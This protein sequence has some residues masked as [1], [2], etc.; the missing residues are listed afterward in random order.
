MCGALQLFQYIFW[1]INSTLHLS[2]VQRK[3]QNYRLT[4]SIN[5]RQL[6]TRYCRT[7]ASTVKS[8]IFTAGASCLPTFTANGSAA[9]SI[10]KCKAPNSSDASAPRC[11]SDETSSAEDGLRRGGPVEAPEENLNNTPYK[12]NYH[13]FY[14]LKIVKQASFSPKTEGCQLENIYTDYRSL[15]LF[16]TLTGTSTRKH[17]SLLIGT[18]SKLDTTCCI[19]TVKMAPIT[20]FSA[21]GTTAL[22][23]SP[24]SGL[25]FRIRWS[26]VPSKF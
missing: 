1:K 23:G 24:T 6:R 17:R 8:L 19:L 14:N 15:A 3:R 4:L 22:H 7:Q 9:S 20:G 10:A 21:W 2:A 18:S 26:H 5:G 13:N 12:K 25:S 11:R 16:P